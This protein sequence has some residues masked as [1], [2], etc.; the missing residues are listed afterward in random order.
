MAEWV[1]LNLHSGGLML[2][3]KEPATCRYIDGIVSKKIRAL[4]NYPLRSAHQIWVQI[5]NFAL[6]Y[7]PPFFF[8][9]LIKKRAEKADRSLNCSRVTGNRSRNLK[10]KSAP[11]SFLMFTRTARTTAHTPPPASPP[12]RIVR[13]KLGFMTA[14]YSCIIVFISFWHTP[15]RRSPPRRCA[16]I[17]T[18]WS[19]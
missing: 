3:F 7:A 13:L 16:V 4:G 6:N 19:R 12:P 17:R 11:L 14:D 2:L 18:T 10:F 8:K 9:N 15:P 1:L 5:H